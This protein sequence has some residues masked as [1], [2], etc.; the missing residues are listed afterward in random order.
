MYQ[1]F[2]HLAARIVKLIPMLQYPPYTYIV[3]IP[4]HPQKYINLQREEVIYYTYRYKHLN[5]KSTIFTS[6][7]YQS[8]FFHKFFADANFFSV[9]TFFALSM[10]F[11]KSYIHMYIVFFYN[12]EVSNTITKI[13][14]IWNPYIIHHIY[15]KM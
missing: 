15:Q 6:H 7:T 14:F 8:F 3:H 1:S 10:I 4:I 9:T 13:V 2:A 12:N 5:Q 11:L